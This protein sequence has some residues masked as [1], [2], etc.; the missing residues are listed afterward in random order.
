MTDSS[1]S[2]VE[3]ELHEEIIIMNYSTPMANGASSLFTMRKMNQARL[4]STDP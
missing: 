4:T 1:Q 2:E 3:L